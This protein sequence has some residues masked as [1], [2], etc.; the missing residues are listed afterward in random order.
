MLHNLIACVVAGLCLW[1]IASPRVPTGIF[2]T[3]GLGLVAIAALWSMDDNHDPVRALDVVLIGVGFVLGCIALRVRR[4]M[5]GAQAWQHTDVLF[6]D[7]SA[8]EHSH[9]AGR[10]R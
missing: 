3:L 10:R 4:Y 2:G 9:I 6:D 1:A 7:V 5:R 8:A